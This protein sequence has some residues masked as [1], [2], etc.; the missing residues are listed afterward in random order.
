GGFIPD[1]VLWL[2]YFYTS[3][4]LPTRLSIF[5]TA[6]S[7]TTIVTSFMAFGILHMRGV[8]GWAGWRWLFLIEGLITLVIGLASF[9]RMP[10][11]A[12][13][14]KKWFRPKG[15][16]T[17]REVRIVVNRVL[18]DD[19]S[20]GDMHNRQ[21]ITPRRLW[22]ALCDY[23]L[24]PIY[25]L[26]LIVYTP[27]VPVR[28]YITLTLKG[29]GFNTFVTNL[30]TIPNS[31]GH[32]ILLLALT[33]LSGY[34]NERSLTSMLQCVWTLPCLAALRFWPGT[35]ENAWGTYSIV[36]ILLSYP[37]CHAIVVGW[38]SRNSN[39]VGT[40]TV[41]AAIYNMCVQLGNIIG[42][43]V[44]REDDKP[45]YR[46]GNTVLFALNILGI[47]LFLAT[48]AYYVLR[49]RHRDKVWNGMTEEEEFPEQIQ[50]EDLLEGAQQLED[51]AY[52]YPE[53]NRVF[54]GA[55]HEDTVN[56]L[57][58]ELKE[59]GYYDVYK[60][61]QVHLW[62]NAEQT[63]SLND[64]SIEAKTMTYS[65]SVDV[66]A[67]IA[68]IKNL[69]CSASDYPS[70][71]AGKIALIKRGECPFGDKSVNAAKAKAAASIVYNNVAGSMAGTLGAAHS[72]KGEYSAIVGISLADG[73]KLISLAEAGAV[74]VDLWVDSQ[75]ENRTTYNVI[76]QTKGGDP[77]NVVAL[78]GHT[79]SVEAGPGINDDGSG[80]ISNLV[81]AK[82][83]TQYSVKH[84]VR[85]LFWTAEEFGL[86]GSD[87]YV[88]HLNGTELNKIRL[89]LNFDM[90][91][92][93]N[94]AIMLYD[95]DGSAF[96][97]S[98]PAGS[99]Q[100]EKLFEDYY[101]S[102]G[103]HHIPTEFDGRS[104]YEAFILNGIP[105]GGVFTGAEGIMS[106]QNAGHFGGQAGLA[107]DANYHAA[108]D[109]MTNLNH[110]AFLINSQATAFAVATY[111]NDLSS[112][113][114]RNATASLHRRARS[115]MK[116][117]G[118]R[119]PRTHAHVSNSGCWHSRVEA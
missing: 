36:T 61:P 83:L 4:E 55:A 84:A 3:K 75:Q 30:L 99:A 76:A 51:F 53:R 66:S 101:D 6:L 29:L 110:E 50:L 8:L 17:D 45:K 38:A 54:G 78:G 79:D 40:R 103:L 47:V 107:Y 67:E 68:V 109:N 27:M 105:A 28:S 19:P 91:A 71:V 16:F 117:F 2:S 96:N 81:V 69:G 20:K 113:P 119:A 25:L 13:E 108:G 22:N 5:W 74:S 70:D 72:D 97:K 37:Y 98:G 62:S 73:Q 44:Y 93:P 86:L 60:Q 65:P 18:R 49:N 10:A 80:I 26:G 1:I 114:K 21:A 82:A 64:E 118:K 87:Y 94:Y 7:V 59:T 102:K 85:F 57:Y 33:R 116:P 100:I 12:V 15:W 24:W 63:L 11:S 41:S 35:M 31:V 34:L 48:K 14:T 112:I 111:A 106:E 88:S 23:D 39:N 89:Y 9:F 46:R 56:Y 115:I 92:S 90:I 52:A 77:N 95:G 104:D 32:I 58:E 42:N 43:N